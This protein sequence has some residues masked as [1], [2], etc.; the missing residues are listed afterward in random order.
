MQLAN[1]S[2][3][4]GRLA[5]L[6]LVIAASML[7]GGSAF[8]AE[9]AEVTIVVFSDFQCP[10]CRQFAP[11]LREVEKNGVEG[12]RTKVEFRNFPLDFHPRAQLAAQAAMAASKQGKFWEMHDLLFANQD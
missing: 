4:F 11:S 1:K 2:F 9:D 5:G 10:F 7:S 8:A 3:R 12:A 6:L